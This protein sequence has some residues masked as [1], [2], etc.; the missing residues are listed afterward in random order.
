M[1][2]TIF[3]AK[4]RERIKSKE[5]MDKRDEETKRY[6]KEIKRIQRERKGG[7]KISV[8]DRAQKEG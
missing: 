8:C 4:I 7:R 2:S 3:K 1:S 5:S 6:E